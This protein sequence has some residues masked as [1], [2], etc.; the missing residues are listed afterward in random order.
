MALKIA[1]N[2]NLNGQCVIDGIVV[3]T[4]TAN[5]NQENPDGMT[6][7]RSILNNSMRKEHRSECIADQVAFEDEAYALQAEMALN[8]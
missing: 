8:V 4:Y 1:K 6:I 3:E 2:M 5:I 7:V